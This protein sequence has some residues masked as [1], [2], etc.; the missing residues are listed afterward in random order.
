MQSFVGPL[1][2]M[3]AA[4]QVQV[5]R[6]EILRRA[7]RAAPLADIE[8]PGLEL[9]HDRTGDRFLRRERVLGL[10]V[11]GFRP[12][13]RRRGVVDEVDGDAKPVPTRADA[14]AQ[15]NRGVGGRIAGVAMGV[16]H[17]GL[18][19]H[20]AQA[21]ELCKAVHRLLVQAAAE[22]PEVMCG[23]VIREGK[24]RDGISPRQR[25]AN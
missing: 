17:A 19:G 7:A 14:A 12:Q 24:D 4:L 21:V 13:V 20:H 10:R 11:E 9:F 5:P 16:R 22:V 6:R 8:K 2:E 3:I 25:S 1:I 23:A 15:E 18:P